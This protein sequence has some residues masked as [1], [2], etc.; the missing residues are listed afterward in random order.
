MHFQLRYKVVFAWVIGLGLFT[1][2]GKN[3]DDPGTEFAPNMYHPVAYEPYVQ[4]K[5][6]EDAGKR[7]VAEGEPSDYE[8][9]NSY[10][11][12]GMS[13]R[14]PVKGTIP[15]RNFQT[16]YGEGTNAV[17]D[18]MIYDIHRDS[19]E[20]AERTLKNP[21]PAT[22]EVLAEGKVLYSRYCQHCHGENGK[23]D[24]LVGKAYKGVPNYSTGNYKTMNSGH[25]YHVI[26][27]G[28]GRM[29]P[30]GSQI[31]PS[32]RWKIVH[33]VHTLQQLD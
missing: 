27:H 26:T 16:V 17:T 9:A 14:L 7:V 31:N 11:P 32:E 30:H 1:A 3:Y 20:V 6:E 15:R 10:N 12:Y 5:N 8:S 21:V 18:L 19:I 24:G 13:M 4:I 25:I 2:C 28:K 22:E 29:W 33:Y 23:G